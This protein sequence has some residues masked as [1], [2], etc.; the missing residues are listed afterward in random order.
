MIGII[1]ILSAIFVY[2]DVKRNGIRKVK[3]LKSVTNMSPAGWFWATLGL[4][5]IAF[6]VYLIIGLCL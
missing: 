3:G 4:W 6:P 1:V 2:W 5:I